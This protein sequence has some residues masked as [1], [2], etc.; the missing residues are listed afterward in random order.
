[1]QVTL[2]PDLRG[3]SCLEAAMHAEGAITIA[4]AIVVSDNLIS[5]N[6]SVTAASS[7]VSGDIES[8]GSINGST[9]AGS[10]T[11]GIDARDMPASSVF[12]YYIA[13]TRYGYHQRYPDS[14]IVHEIGRD[15][16]VFSVIRGRALQ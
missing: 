12:D 1:M 7:T 15:G 14:P 2:T 10:T 5:S 9:Y 4:S 6:L 3:L 11:S 8:V 16:A 13:T